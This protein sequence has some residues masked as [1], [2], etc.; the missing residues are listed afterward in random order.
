MSITVKKN[1]LTYRESELIGSK[2]EALYKH[3]APAVMVLKG[4]TQLKEDYGPL[5]NMFTEKKKSN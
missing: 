5:F 1:S 4:R 3:L 2:T